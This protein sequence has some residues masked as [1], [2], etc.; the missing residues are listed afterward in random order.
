MDYE[1]SSQ[2]E[3]FKRVKP[4]LNSKKSE[5]DK[6]GYT[7]INIMDIWNYLIEN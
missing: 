6:L 4:A 1:F 3:L 5:L 2:E 7:Y